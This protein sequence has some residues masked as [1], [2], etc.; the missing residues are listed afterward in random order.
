VPTDLEKTLAKNKTA[1]TYFD[2]FP[3]STKRAILEWINN[4]VKPETRAKRVEATA[5]LAA[6]NIRANQP[7]QVKR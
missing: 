2:A 6:D 4:A 5:R 7:R 3:R 1:Q